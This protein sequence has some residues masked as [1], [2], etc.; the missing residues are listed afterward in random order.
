MFEGLEVPPPTQEADA[1]D[2]HLLEK[3]PSSSAASQACGREPHVVTNMHNMGRGS[4]GMPPGAEA[5]Q[6][7]R[8]HPPVYQKGLQGIQGP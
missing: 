5:I 7:L 4:P 2:F 3:Q 1:T 6:G 8:D